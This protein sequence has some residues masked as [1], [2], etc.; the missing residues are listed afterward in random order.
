MTLPWTAIIWSLTA[1]SLLTVGAIHFGI[2]RRKR[3]DYAQ[4]AFA[5]FG[6]SLALVVVGEM[7][8][9]QAQTPEQFGTILR[10][11][12]LPGLAAIVSVAVFIRIY[13]RG[14][15]LWLAYGACG[16]RLL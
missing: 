4:L 2:W 14:G 11:L 3:S 12:H 13:L 8:M 1:G 7:L 5:A 16:L 9:M 6:G 10:W 15:R